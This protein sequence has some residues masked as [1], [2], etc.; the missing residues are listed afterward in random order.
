MELQFIDLGKLSISKASMRYAKKAP[1]VSDILP[2]VRKR[3][4]IVPV[5]VRP[6]CAP[7]AY[8]IVAGARRFTA[9]RIVAEER[10]EAGQ[11]VDPMPCAILGESDDADAIE[12]SLIENVARLDPDE[13]TRWQ[14]FTRLVK[15][16]RDVAD[17]SATFGLPDMMVR[18]VLALGNLMPRIRDL[19]RAEKID[20]ATVR[21]LTMAS[22]AQQ[23]AWLALYDDEDAYVP[24][25]H[26]L[27]AWL[28]GGQS[29]PVRH[30]LFDTEGMKGIVAD[31]FGEDKYF[32]DADAF[33]TAQND[34]IEVRRDDYLDAGW[35]DVVIVPAGEHFSTWE[36]EKAPKRKGGHIYIDVRA[37]G[38]V[39]FH[40]GYVTRKEARRIEKGEP[41]NTGHKPPRPE[42]TGTCQT[43]I[44]LHRH[45]AVR[46]ALT[47]HPKVALRLMVAHAIVGS[48]LWTVK[49]EPQTTRNEG[50]RESVE[51]CKGEADF[52]EKRRAVLGLLDFSAEEPTVTGGNGD[53]YGL[54]GVFLRLLD[55]PDRA[56]MDVIA[57]VI[58]E[59]LAAG[60]AAVEAVGQEI[61]VDMARYWQA[62]DAFFELIRDREVLT[63]IVADVAGP[64]IA[65]ANAGEK[66]KTLKTIVRNHLDG[67]DGRAKVTGW[68][69]KWMVF[70]PSAYTTRGGVGT[71]AKAASMAA[72]RM[73]EQPDPADPGPNT[74]G[75]VLALPAPALEPDPQPLAA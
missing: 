35:S 51:T 3:G 17:I 14:T 40:E 28:F 54:V 38:E 66:S 46:A 64:T 71:L 34:A 4:V 26:Q 72:A 16:G 36:Y 49:S 42:V 5:L 27:K 8:E 69:P 24:T 62:D 29:I 73:S 30:A 18:R 47:G 53:D 48:H 32:A 19:Y 56:V 75:N 39:S 44:D 20:A 65:N 61:G 52:D 60:S 31:L 1:D 22:K 23:R 33:W 11:D 12:A 70:P 68:V 41:L 59:T 45:A 37:N 63:H 21:H 55:L 67:V 6:N 25:G 58:G 15:E 57:I 50:I 7:D 13:V 43:Y 2:T 9:A 74:S 10:R